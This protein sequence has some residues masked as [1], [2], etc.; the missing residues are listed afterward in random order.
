MRR[1]HTHC[2]SALW[3]A[4]LLTSSCGDDSAG[5]VAVTA[6]PPPPTIDA[7]TVAGVEQPIGTAIDGG[8]APPR[9]IV[10][11][12]S[13]YQS[14]S[15]S[16]LDPDGQLVK[17][18]CIHSGSGSAGLSMTLSEDLA[19]PSQMPVDS[20]PV[21]ID[22]GNAT[23]TWVD[24]S[25]CA[26]LR[27]MPVGTGFAANPHDFV[28]ISAS[29]AYVTRFKANIAA[30][31]APDDLDDGNDVLIIDPSQGTL[32]GRIDLLP[33]APAGFL[34]RADRALL[35]DGKVYLSLNATDAKFT[36]YATGRIVIIDPVADQVVGSVDFPGAKNCGA[37]TYL[38]AE[39]KLVVA[40]TGD[41]VEVDGSAI[42]VVDTSASPPVM[43][44]KIDAVTTA[45]QAFSNGSVAALDSNTIFAV[46]MGDFSNLPPDVM[47]VLAQNGAAPIGLYSSS[48]AF[49]MGAV[50][51]DAGRG[52]VFLADGTMLTP[53]AVRIFER[54]GAS[55]V[56]VGQ[57][58][59]NPSH[60]LP[61]RGLAWF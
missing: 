25:S 38:S 11:I 10:V 46:A 9:G 33:F 53:A 55:F 37:M 48:E 56:E 39:K 44:A 7:G 28:Q 6:V 59:T 17:D 16:F 13:D 50:L 1:F 61:A 40:C 43:V 49:T 32:V 24:P 34:P 60:K 23:L 26:A 36:T 8:V 2:M 57:I 19:L 35:A 21:I 20:P 22:R 3:L 29:K 14:S 42:V 15:V 31:P 47:W 52:R 27:Q 5:P 41:Y 58:K 30:T 51:V 45:K 54:A 12:H 4:C 18:G